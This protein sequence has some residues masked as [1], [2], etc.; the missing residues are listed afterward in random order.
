MVWRLAGLNGMNGQHRNFVSVEPARVA[1][2]VKLKPMHMWEGVAEFK[3]CDFIAVKV[4]ARPVSLVRL[5]YEDHSFIVTLGLL[6][7]ADDG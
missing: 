6:P 7:H 4:R 1:R 3:V 2:P 5:C